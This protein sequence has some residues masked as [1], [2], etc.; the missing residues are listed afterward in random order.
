MDTCGGVGTCVPVMYIHGLSDQDFGLVYARGF[1]IEYDGFSCAC[2][3]DSGG[4]NGGFVRLQT[5]SSS[6]VEGGYGGVRIK[7][8]LKWAA[9]VAIIDA[10]AHSKVGVHSVYHSELPCHKDDRRHQ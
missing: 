6:L 2:V 3:P 5:V 8:G 1:S 10:C 9:E 4:V 7:K